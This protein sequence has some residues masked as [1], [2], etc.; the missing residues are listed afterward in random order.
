MVDPS[1]RFPSTYVT[2]AT[3]LATTCSGRWRPGSPSGERAYA[4]TRGRPPGCDVRPIRCLSARQTRRN[5]D[6]RLSRWQPAKLTNQSGPHIAGAGRPAANRIT[7]VIPRP[8]GRLAAG[9]KAASPGVAAKAAA[10]AGRVGAVLRVRAGLA[11]AGVWWGARAPGTGEWSQPRAVREA[12]EPR[13]LGRR[14]GG[15]SLIP[16]K[17]NAALA[18]ARLASS[19]RPPGSELRPALPWQTLAARRLLPAH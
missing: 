4:G 5:S 14:L 12:S 1:A 19:R 18:A 10:R 13:M 3:P 9:A 2:R 15:S 6:T 8:R 11:A 16:G 17:G 7:R